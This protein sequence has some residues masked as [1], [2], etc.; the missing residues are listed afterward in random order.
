MKRLFFKICFVAAILFAQVSF[1]VPAFKGLVK[2]S[3]PNGIE[4]SVYLHGDERLSWT[5]SEDNYTLLRNAQ[6]NLEYAV[7][8]TYDDLVPSGILA[9]N[10]NERS[11]TDINFLSSVRKNLRY[12][13]TQ[14]NLALEATKMMEN[15]N[16]KVTTKEGL[17]SGIRKL[18]V[19][20]V[21]YPSGTYNSQTVAAVPFT[22]TR[23]RFE[24]IFNQVGYNFGG[25]TGSVRDYF[26]ATSYGKLDLQSTIVGPFTLPQNRKFYGAESGQVND[27][28]SKQMIIDALNLA[29]PTVDFT[30]YDNDGDLKL[31]GIHVVYAGQGQH[32]GGGTDAIWAHRGRLSP[33]LVLDGVQIVDYSCASEKRSY[34]EMSGIGVHCHE[35]GHV[36]GL[37]D[38]YD[39][40]YE[41]NGV[42]KTLGD[43]ETMDAGAYNN[44]EKTP[45]MYNAY[46]LLDLG[47]AD[48][49]EIDSNMLVDITSMPATD[50]NIV[51]KINTTT[52]GEYFLF[53]NRYR[54]GWDQYFFSGAGSLMG[55][56]L[57]L[58]VDKNTQGWST[59]CF[60]CF[61][62]HNG[63]KLVSADNTYN[64]YGSSAWYYSSTSNLLFPG[65]SNITKISDTNTVSANLK[66][67]A[68][69]N[70][71]VDISNISFQTGGNI[72]FKV[73]GGASYGVNVHTFAPTAIAHTSANLGGSIVPST[74]GDTAIIEAGIVFDT[75]PF[76]RNNDNNTFPIS[77]RGNFTY[78]VTNLQAG[79]EYYY[80]TYGKNSN[81]IS[82]GENIKFL[83][84]SD[85]I[86]NNFILDSNFAA[87][88]SGEMPTV[89]GSIPVGGSGVYSYK[90]LQSTDSILF[91]ETINPGNRKD[92]TPS[93]LTVPT[94]YKRIVLSADKVDTTTHKLVPIV[95]STISGSIVGENSSIIQHEST[96]NIT[97]SGHTGNIEFWQRKK[98]TDLWTSISASAMVNPFS[99][100]LDEV[101]TYQYRVRV[102]NGACPFKYSNSISLIVDEVSLTDVDN[103][104]INFN[105]Y[106]NPTNGVFT[107]DLGSESSASLNLSV[108]NILGKVVF[109]KQNLSTKTPINIETA[110]N[111]TYIIVLKEGDKIVGAK[112]II[113]KK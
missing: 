96:G 110:E 63:V 8:N 60:N 93:T 29:N 87:C 62:S 80:R 27:I 17:T 53:Q 73:N 46:S 16:T 71:K 111:G 68:G 91:T 81:G 36:L 51:Y 41:D 33:A 49:Y 86:T 35:F 40:D 19:I 103:Q 2:I 12:S 72:T 104:K 43:F 38:Y 24:N 52:P 26:R 89:I 69:A 47:W 102:R 105:I 13:E 67:W 32:N 57:L 65:S 101:G 5:S 20:L 70:S 15:K 14:I 78:T 83:T 50:T 30:Q 37:W 82:Y 39:T 25:A 75:L 108:I 79:K 76:P 3:Q 28:N 44:Y 100:I 34:N 98:G 58:Q 84:T 55:G 92:Y 88:S 99:E 94:Y 11:I 59:N 21:D 54:E 106:P 112:Q 48:V 64:G 61:S 113:I 7:K 85:N 4:I 18:L 74:L 66:S 10:V 23:E 1:A 77:Q 31:D 6:G 107:L 42:S 97:L 56:L 22:Y 95:D 9:K 90:W 109:E 45:P